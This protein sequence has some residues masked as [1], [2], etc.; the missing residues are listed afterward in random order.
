[1]PNPKEDKA[2][3]HKNDSSSVSAAH[4]Q[5]PDL[6]NRVAYYRDPFEE[7]VRQ[8]LG[9]EMRDKSFALGTRSC[10]SRRRTLAISVLVL[11]I[12]M[13]LG[14]RFG[15][16]S[17]PQETKAS[18]PGDL[19]TIVSPNADSEIDLEVPEPLPAVVMDSTEG[20][21]QES[22]EKNLPD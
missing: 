10:N 14:H 6:A 4:T 3:L 1:M 17:T 18:A 16:R 22:A 9:R 11:I 13:V 5:Q 20:P 7:A 12:I 2:G 19:P 8:T 21:E 15:L